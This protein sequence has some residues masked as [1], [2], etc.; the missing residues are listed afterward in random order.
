MYKIS[1]NEGALF[2]TETTIKSD[3]S[4]PFT[5]PHTF[6]TAIDLLW[7]ASVQSVNVYHS[8][9]QKLWEYFRKHFKYIE[10]AGGLVYNAVR[11]TLFIYR[12]GKWDL[13]KGKV[14]EGENLEETAIREVEEECGISNLEIIK[15]LKIAYHIY[16]YETYILKVVHWYEMYTPDI[17]SLNPKKEENILKA[18]WKNPQEIP[19]VLKN[20]YENIRALF[21]DDSSKTTPKTS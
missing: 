18:I 15:P 3:K 4:F 16:H 11:H 21:D 8:D 9:V 1:I 17:T 20:T 19:E 13:P 6:D 12:L 2:L 10:A 7:N 5:S 14:E